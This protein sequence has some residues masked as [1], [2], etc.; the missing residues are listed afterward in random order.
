MPDAIPRHVALRVRYDETVRE[1][2]RLVSI[3][4]AE[5]KGNNRFGVES[6]SLSI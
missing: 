2:S 1:I 6:I 4:V 3:N 5:G